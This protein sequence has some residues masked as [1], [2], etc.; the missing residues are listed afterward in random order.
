M[1]TRFDV[2]IAAAAV[3]LMAA[4]SAIAVVML[5]HDV[6]HAGASSALIVAGSPDPAPAATGATPGRGPI[7]IN[8]VGGSLTHWHY[9]AN[10]NFNASGA[11]AP[12]A[13]GFNL[14]DASSVSE[15]NSLPAGDEALV[16]VGLCIAAN[17]PAFT[18]SFTSRLQ[19]Y[20]NNSRVFGFY[21]MD[22]PDPRSC[23]PANLAAESDWIHA[24]IPGARTFIVLMNVQGPDSPSYAGTYTPQN[25][26]V[27]LV[28]IDPYPVRAGLAVPDY[29]E[30]LS[31]V[32]AAEAAGWSESSLVPVFQ[33]FG[34]GNWG[35]TWTLPTPAQEQ[36]IL[37]TWAT[38]LP[39]PAFDYTYSWGAQ[40]GDSSLASSPTL[41]RIFA[42]HNG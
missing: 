40:N 33:A 16:Y 29:A 10:G 17:D 27:D 32:A 25:S 35:G 4:G 14:A 24:N 22:E 6:G 31:T 42:T 20:M 39:A 41:Q 26:H 12:G 37:A 18:S 21:L 34:G 19:H 23:P 5:P 8:Q 36:Q 3:V 9:T 28:G 2:V 11:Y 13:V 1:R 7:K 30:I 38:L 15:V